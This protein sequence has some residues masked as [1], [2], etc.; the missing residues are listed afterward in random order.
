[1][2]DPEFAKSF[3]IEE[4][5]LAVTEAVCETLNTYGFKQKEYDLVQRHAELLDLVRNW[6]QAHSMIKALIKC[7]VDV[8]NEVKV[9]VWNAEWD[10]RKPVLNEAET[11]LR[12]FVR[13]NRPA[14]G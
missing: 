14:Q 1:M 11:A 9:K 5:I 10:R 12:E 4:L 2:K 6:E 7:P 3:F 8:Q 13:I